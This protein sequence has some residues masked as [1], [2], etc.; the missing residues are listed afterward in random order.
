MTLAL[1]QPCGWPMAEKQGKSKAAFRR[2]MHYTPYQE[3]VC[4]G[5]RSAGQRATRPTWVATLA[6]MGWLL[7]NELR[8]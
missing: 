6:M 8:E 1:N 7:L 2:A 5:S 4:L 3:A